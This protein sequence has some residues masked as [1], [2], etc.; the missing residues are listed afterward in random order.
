M[1]HN[2]SIF[3]LRGISH[4]K[5]DQSTIW[6]CDIDQYL[7]HKHKLNLPE[8]F[9]ITKIPQLQLQYGYTCGYHA[10]GT[11][12]DYW[13]LIDEN[14]KT[15]P[16]TRYAAKNKSTMT[17]KK[18][19]VLHGLERLGGIFDVKNIATILQ[20]TQYCAHVESFSTEDDMC[21]KIIIALQH[22]I[23][24]I[25]AID[26]LDYEAVEAG[27]KHAHFITAIGYFKNSVGQT[28]IIFASGAFYYT[29][30]PTKLFKSSNN[31]SELPECAYYKSE[32]TG[33][34]LRS[35]KLDD[36]LNA[37]KLH[38]QETANLA[39]LR[40]QLVLVYPKVLEPIYED[41]YSQTKQLSAR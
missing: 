26:W 1:L 36:L 4:N 24:V 8:S 40:N 14:Y 17:L 39:G 13:N 35:T 21:E 7:S 3:D 22:Q 10:I 25:M 28:E 9:A 31:L 41:I 19:G 33:D 30:S 18:L 11:A 34:W 23:P 38:V 27:G 15:I 2:H 37:K 6:I 29:A 5:T 12:T 16:P 32:R 20:T